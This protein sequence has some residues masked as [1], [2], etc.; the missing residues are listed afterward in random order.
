M[1]GPQA[2]SFKV[3]LWVGA[4][5][6]SIAGCRCEGPKRQDAGTGDG[7]ENIVPD[8]DAGLVGDG[9]LSTSDSGELDAGTFDSGVPDAGIPDAGDV[10][11]GAPDSGT[12]DAGP[13]DAGPQPLPDA[14]QA[15]VSATSGGA[16]LSSPN[17]RL[18]L[19][20]MP[21][22]PVSAATDAGSSLGP[23]SGR[24]P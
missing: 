22:S 12:P 15:G 2:H 23:S 5:T 24:N 7:G 21:A 1:W 20:A 10:D 16:L 14:G 3:R 4:L 6:L 9:G 11:S 17:Y 8:F 18:H 13:L 19:F